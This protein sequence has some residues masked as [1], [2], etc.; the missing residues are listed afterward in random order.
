MTKRRSRELGAT[1]AL[2]VGRRFRSRQYL[3]SAIILSLALYFAA[4]TN[5]SACSTW[6]GQMGVASWYGPRFMGGR[7]ATGER[8]DM[9]AM[10][11]AHSCLPLGTKV[12]VTVVGTGRSLVVTVNDRMPPH[13]RILD[14][15]A[16][17]AHALGIAS[18]GIATVRLSRT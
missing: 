12:R 4:F 14:L 13:R 3:T 18:Q 8:F 15:S 5:A 17:A 9:W 16:G 6:D 2:P 7:T 10:T 1:Q 11:A